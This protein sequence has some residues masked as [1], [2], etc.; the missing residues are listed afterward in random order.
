MLHNILKEFEEYQE[1]RQLRREQLHRESER[2]SKEAFRNLIVMSAG[3]LMLMG[4][5]SLWEEY[6]ETN[7]GIALMGII[8]IVLCCITAIVLWLRHLK[9]Q[10]DI[11]ILNADVKK[12]GNDQAARLAEKYRDK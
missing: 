4:L 9:R 1:R 10:H 12:I 7:R 2:R 3:L 11:D 6:R 8:F 5:M